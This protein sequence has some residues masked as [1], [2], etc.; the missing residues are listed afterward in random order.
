M[1]KILSKWPKWDKIRQNS[2]KT[3]KKHEKNL[4]FKAKLAQNVKKIW[5]ILQKFNF[6][7]RSRHRIWGKIKTNIKPDV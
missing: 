7:N 2:K 5:V 6:K 1:E 3:L 4:Y